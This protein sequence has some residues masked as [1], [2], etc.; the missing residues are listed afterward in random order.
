MNGGKETGAWRLTACLVA[1]LAFALGLHPIV[2]EDFFWHLASGRWILEHRAVPRVD[3][4]TY[5]LTDRPWLNFQWVG[6][7]VMTLLWTWGGACAVILAKVFVWAGAFLL[8]LGVARAG[9]AG[10]TSAGLISTLALFACAERTL[11]RPEA[12]TYLFLAV[13]LALC[14]SPR[15]TWTLFVAA[16]FVLHVVWINVHS[17]AFLG[18]LLLGAFTLE[19]ALRGDSAVRRLLFA[20]LAAGVG[21]LLNPY[22]FAAWAFPATLFNRI[23]RG[24]AVFSRVLEFQSPLQSFGDAPLR[25]FWLLVLLLV[26]ALGRV[27]IDRSF[28]SRKRDDGEARGG[29]GWIAA[30]LFLGLALMAR[31]N[32][33]LFA[34]VATPLLAAQL[35]SLAPLLLRIHD[36]RFAAIIRR[37]ARAVPGFAAIAILLGASTPWFGLY[38]DRG[39]GVELGLFP[40][41]ALRVLD[42]SGVEKPLFNDLEFGG[43]ISW[44]DSARKTFIDGRLEVCGPERLATYLDAHHRPEVWN[45]LE[46][47]WEFGALLVGHEFPTSV[48]FLVAQLRSGHWRL[49]SL[50]PRAALLL[51]TDFNPGSR[52]PFASVPVA[53]DIPPPEAADWR[54]LLRQS[55]G[56]EPHAGSSLVSIDRGLAW[57]CRG[58]TRGPGHAPVRNAGRL[59]NVWLALGS[60]EVARTGYEEILRVAPRD[61]EAIYNLGLCELRLGNSSRAKTHWE[62]HLDS[63]DP[64]TRRRIEKALRD[65]PD[66]R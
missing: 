31:R 11:E 23:D 61:A 54:E 47:S 65:L 10:P 41:E 38:R 26:V 37:I 40:E 63:V 45:R 19:A 13:L 34:L 7:V 56:P 64:V 21:L 30:L 15:L 51:K 20:T 42:R 12:A 48:S 18:P 5:S 49:A 33:P 24:D 55:R 32:I 29:T 58:L 6:D 53:F 60:P 50:S 44:W 8:L 25:S 66:V 28:P 1:L 57:V 17:L 46:S 52:E 27:F 4:L 14:K 35:E 16:V 62:S 22:G 36:P 43:A 3:V 2:S 39:I 59:A 9:G